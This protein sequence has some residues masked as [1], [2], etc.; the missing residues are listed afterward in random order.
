MNQ[1][2]RD[3]N[4]ESHEAAVTSK[5]DTQITLLREIRDLLRELV[6]ETRLGPPM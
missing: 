4:R 5:V 2:A 3:A 6:K 1:G